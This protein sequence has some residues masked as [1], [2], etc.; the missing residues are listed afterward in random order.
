MFNA[1]K[2]S[3]AVAVALLALATTTTAHAAKIESTTYTFDSTKSITDQFGG[4]ATNANN[5]VFAQI[6][7]DKFD[8]DLGVLTG[9]SINLTSTRT[10]TTTVSVNAATDQG[11]NNT[12]STTG[13]GS[14]AGTI[15]TTAGTNNF[16]AV[17]Q[18]ATCA[19]NR[20]SACTS[21]TGP[22]SANQNVVQNASANALN[23]FAGTTNPT[24]SLRAST[25]SATQGASS[26]AGDESTTFTAQWAG[27]LGVTYRYLLHAAGSFNST[28][29]QSERVLDFGT[30]FQ[31][32]V[33]PVLNF[34]IFNIADADR[35]GLD[36]NSRNRSGDFMAFTSSFSSSNNL[37][38]G[39]SRLFSAALDTKNLGSF[40]ATYT[41]NLSDANVGA[42]ST[43]NDAFITLNLTGNVV[44]RAAVPEPFSLA[45]LGI[46]LAGIAASRRRKA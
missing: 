21:T 3:Q 14:F 7:I 23:N 26:F 1:N 5:T 30:V 27:T 34:R 37:A 20:D 38:Q 43:R 2:I 41:F 12:R 42:A 28:N 40:N 36:F 46:G 6:E 16:P 44:D 11:A 9:A 19:A 4:G 17:S 32:A 33:D 18:S 15:S 45:L 39:G 13:S 8:R 10:L 24:A 29:Q 35:V 22:V 31:N 25:F